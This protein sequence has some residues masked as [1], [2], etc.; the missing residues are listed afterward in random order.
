MNKLLKLQK[1][2][3]EAVTHKKA[4]KVLKKYYKYI[5][6]QQRKKNNEEITVWQHLSTVYSPR[7]HD[8]VTVNTHCPVVLENSKRGQ[9][10]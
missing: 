10:K 6:K 5:E 8:R 4:T 7:K 3:E 1:Q 2:A 9:G